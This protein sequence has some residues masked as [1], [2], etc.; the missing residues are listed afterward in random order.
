MVAVPAAMPYR[1]A[2][3]PEAVIDATLVLEL[4][5]APPGVVLLKVAEAASQ[6]VVEPVI[7][8][9]AEFTLITRVA[10]LPHPVE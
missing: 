3:D 2:V 6:T 9:G 8:D 5:H 4:L 10:G 7:A 1:V